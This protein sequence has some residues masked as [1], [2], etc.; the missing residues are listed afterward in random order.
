MSHP[1]NRHRLARHLQA[2]LLGVGAL[3]T[4]TLQAAEPVSPAAVEDV[5]QYDIAAGPLAEVLGRFASAA[6]VALSFDAAQTGGRRSDGLR[7]AYS[8]DAGFARLLEGSGLRAIDAGGSYVLEKRVDSGDALELGATRIAASGLGSTTEGTGSYTTG[9]VSVGKLPNQTLRDTPQSVSV[10]TRQRI[11]DQRLNTINDV[12]TQTTG[13]SAYEG[14]TNDSRYLARGFE[15]TNFRVDGGAPVSTATFAS[16]DMDMAI[17]DHVEILRGADGL[18]SG[19]GEPGGSVNLVRKRPTAV[20]QFSMTQSVGSWDNYRTELD[21]SGPLGFDGRLRGRSVIVYQDRNGYMD[22]FDSDRK[23]FHGVLEADLTDSTLFTIGYTRDRFN[24]A[25][26][27][28]GLPRYSDGSD[29]GLSRSVFLAGSHDEMIRDR[30]SVYARIEQ[31]LSAD[32]TATVDAIHAN[33]KQYRDYYNFYGAIDPLT[34]TGSTAGWSYQDETYR[35]RSIDLSLK[36]GFDLLGGRHDAVLGYTWQNSRWPIDAYSWASGG[37]VSAGDIFAFDPDD[38]PSHRGDIYRRSSLQ[39]YSK[40]NGVYGSLRL[41][42]ADPLHL[43]L[44]G[45]YNDYYYNWGFTGYD[46]A[47]AETFSSGTVYSDNN[48]FTPFAALT[49][50]LND[51]WTAYTSAADI[52][53]SQASSL[54]G[55][56]PG[57]SPLDPIRGR[58]YEIGIK[59]ELFDGRLNTTTALYY[60]KREGEAMLDTRYPPTES[61]QG[62]SCCWLDDGEVTS[63]GV[64]FEISG[65]ITEGLEG[66][67]G[68]TYNH[69]VATSSNSTTNATALTLTPKHL[70]K[71]FL[72]YRMPGALENLRVGAGVSAQSTSYVREGSID[73]S[74]AGYALYSAFADYRLNEHWSVVLN[75]NNLADKKYY[76]TLGN[77]NYGNFYGDPRNF[78]LT[79]RGTY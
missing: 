27:T 61:G 57:S 49:Y 52:Y 73:M 67:F 38:Y 31:R 4:A 19:N 48:V 74:Q 71:A 17:Y 54:K 79:L 35:D 55:P 33:N 47:G 7:G 14:G 51:E 70:G 36:G 42:L 9:Q 3:T 22:K 26:Q 60:I 58:A 32:W 46:T 29:L 30:D 78:V 10:I 39:T 28:Y 53:L 40:Q 44:G 20:S 62:A 6:G 1:F 43:I 68:Y 76:S 56:P 18:Y 15:I 63:K 41:Q 13:I 25:D 5:R 34:H 65:Q 69:N 59:G 75:G 24:A 2:A 37:Q 45:R 8:V 72:T 16:K 21:I 64:E 77:T 23:L 12:L 11:E 66:T 50:R